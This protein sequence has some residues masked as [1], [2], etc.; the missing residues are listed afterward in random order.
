[1]VEYQRV[2]LLGWDSDASA[3]V[4]VKVDANGKAVVAI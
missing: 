3:W 2:I 1:M 4:P